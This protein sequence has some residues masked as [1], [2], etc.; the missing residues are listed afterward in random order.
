MKNMHVLLPLA[1]LLLALITGCSNKQES[2]S[3]MIPAPKASSSKMDMKG[4]NAATVNVDLTE[5]AIALKPSTA[6]AGMIHFM[7]KNSGKVVHSFAIRG[8]GID[9]KLKANLAPGATDM[10]MVTLKAGT[11][12]TYCPIPGHTEKGM[13]KE[14]KVE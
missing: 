6:K 11:Y 4:M 14:F 8:N 12:E 1:L 7:V 10:L 3:N 13:K 9:E 5:M 2:A